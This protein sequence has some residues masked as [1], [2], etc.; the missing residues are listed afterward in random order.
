LNRNAPFTEPAQSSKSF[1]PVGPPRVNINTGVFD[2]VKIEPASEP[3]VEN[4]GID[5]SSR[6]SVANVR[7]MFEV[8]LNNWFVF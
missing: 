4:E 6:D 7:K 1:T 5:T 3:A 2:N 8:N